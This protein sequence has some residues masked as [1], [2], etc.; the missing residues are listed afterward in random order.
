MK[1][2]FFLMSV[3]ALCFGASSHAAD[4]GVFV[5][6]RLQKPDD[7]KYYVKIGGVVHQANWFLA[8]KIF[9]AEPRITSGQFTDWIDLK[10]Y[11]GTNLHSRLNLAGGI[12]ELPNIIT[13]FVVEPASPRREVE[14]ELATAP[15]EAKIVKRWRENFE[16]DMMSFLV[17]PN[18]ATDVA[19][20]E[21]DTEMTE[22]RL[23]WAREA[24]GGKRHAPKQLMVQTAFWGPQ[25]PELHLKDAEILWLLGFNVVGGASAE[26]R[27][28]FPEFRSPS[29]SHDIPLGPDSDRDS[30]HA[31]WEKI[32]PQVKDGYSRGAPFYF[33]DEICARGT[34]NTNE[35]ALKQ[36]RDW[37][38]AQKFSPSI[39]GVTN[40]DLVVPLE[41]PEAL[42]EKMKT[43]ERAARR[44]FYYTSRFRQ[45]TTT[46]RLIWSSEE[47]HRRFSTEHVSATLV[48]DH[49][50]FSGTGFGMGMDQTNTAWGGWPLAADWFDIGKRRAVDMIGIEDW[51][52][53]QFMYGPDFTWEGFQLMGFQ[54]SIFRSASRG[55]MPI[56][57]WIT[58][59]DE[60]NLRLKA[61]SALAQGSKNF[62]YWTY[63]PT[64]T[65]TENYWSDQPGSYPG[66]AQLSHV[67]EFG[68]KIIAPGKPRPTR[69]ALLYSISSDLWQTYGYAQM[70]ERRGIYLALIH[71]QYLV[72]LVTEEDV[73]AGHLKNYI[74]LYT[75]DPCIRSDAAKLIGSW[76]KDGGTLV[77]TCAAGSRNEFGEP[78]A[79]LAKVF[80][81]APE[82]TADIQKGDYRM[83]AALNDI[84]HRDRVKFSGK[85]S[86]EKEFGVIGLKTDLQPRGSKVKATFA[87]N[88]SPALVENRF[89]KGRAIYF[90]TTPGISYIKDAKFVRT[91]L[92]EKWPTEQRWALTHFAAEAKAASLVKL[93]EPVVEAGIYE[94]PTGSALILANF[95]YQPIKTLKVEIPTRT[96]VASI[97]SLAHGSIK[98]ETIR[99]PSPWREE[100]YKHL[101]RFSLPLDQDDILILEAR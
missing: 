1:I 41:T 89:G 84:P 44:N 17:S 35:L 8:E 11:A 28:K 59:S 57:T 70:L 93:S 20:L 9:S 85:E 22:R 54:A 55:E 18:L 45:E 66:M 23:R 33:Q 6:F 39:F 86:A 4:D 27:A 46:D 38:K 77:A 87:S 91:A 26:A 76:V 62:F 72:D 79:E 56:M 50:Y 21:T 73:A 96:A 74:I 52:G 31:V 80:G 99:V 82:I 58:P 15:D 69:V 71:E 61:A 78:T 3:A 47:L 30:V 60:H 90:A 34:V 98:F 2:K 10:A 67:L 49:P 63:G 64:S 68:E 95:T 32:Y 51:L 43:D 36:F 37:L 40:L 81:I 94:A 88:G 29:A 92:A 97:K 42:R 25:R 24:T 13:T 19:Q 83:R 75:A 12:A 48:A 5:R 65:S 53:L 16:G 101:Q 7:A 100:G 14:I